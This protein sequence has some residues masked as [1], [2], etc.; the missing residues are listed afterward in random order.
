MAIG[1]LLHFRAV[2]KTLYIRWQ[3][4]SV[5]A[6]I[7]RKIT[8]CYGVYGNALSSSED[9]HLCK[10]APLALD[11]R[12]GALKSAELDLAHFRTKNVINNSPQYL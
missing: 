7:Q 11:A 10:S 12:F 5:Q 6:D 3:A 2:R 4:K 9:Q 1:V 8:I